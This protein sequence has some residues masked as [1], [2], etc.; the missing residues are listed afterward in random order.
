[1]KVLILAG[2]R[3]KRLGEISD[4]KNKCMFEIKEKPLIQYSLD[5]ASKS[6]IS[7]IV[8]VV[9]HKAKEIIDVYGDEY[10]GKPIKYVMQE[11][12]KGLVHAIECAEDAIGGEDFMLMLGDELMINPKHSEMIKEYR[13]KNL[14]VICGM[15]SVKDKN[16]I[17]KTYSVIQGENNRI[18]RLIEK[19]DNPMNNMMGTG[20]CIFKNEI[21]S[22]ISQTPIN[23]KRGEKELPDL[24]Q[25][26]I[27]G[28]KIV[29]SFI[30]CDKYFNLN[31]KEDIEDAQS[32]FAHF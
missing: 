13:N 9:G 32:Y 23:Q 12:Q 15:I 7:E 11:E 31:L 25:C 3:G 21:F 16:L 18:L 14:F 22:Y 29:K 27:D 5:W 1:M 6:D 2:G 20:N 28:G 19:P 8:I 30:I 24:I 10:N 17:K 4:D 26:V